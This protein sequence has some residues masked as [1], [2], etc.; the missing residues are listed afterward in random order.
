[1]P[2]LQ[3]P[4]NSQKTLDIYSINPETA[5]LIE[6][7]YAQSIQNKTS[8]KARELFQQLTSSTELSKLSKAI[9]NKIQEI[10]AKFNSE[11]FSPDFLDFKTAILDTDLSNVPN[12]DTANKHPEFIKLINQLSKLKAKEVVMIKHTLKK[13]H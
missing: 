5:G 12:L 1:M 13:A 7:V 3:G 11:T 4:D 10:T 6:V 9:R 8:G 2:P